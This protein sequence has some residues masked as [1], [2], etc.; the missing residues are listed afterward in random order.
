M[1]VHH[2]AMTRPTDA[3]IVAVERLNEG[4]LVKF[5]G[6]RCVFYR[7]ELLYEIIPRAEELDEEATI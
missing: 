3:R 1:K 4:V 5:Q 7:D 2:S 6:G